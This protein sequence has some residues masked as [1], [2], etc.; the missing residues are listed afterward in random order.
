[1][2][3]HWW[4]TRDVSTSQDGTGCFYLAQV[5]ESKEASKWSRRVVLDPG[6]SELPLFC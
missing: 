6:I 2:V 3:S 5:T 1:M 4:T